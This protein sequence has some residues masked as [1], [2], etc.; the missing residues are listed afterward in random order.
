MIPPTEEHR[1]LRNIDRISE[2]AQYTI[3]E[4]YIIRNLKGQD[5]LEEI[6]SSDQEGILQSLTG[7]F[8]VPGLVYTFLYKGD[9]LVIEI[10]EKKTEFT[11][12]VPLVFCMNTGQGYFTGLNLN[13]LPGGVRLKFLQAFYETFK[14]FFNKI[15][16]LTDNN[17]LAWNKRFVEFVKSGGTQKMLKVFNSKTAS[18]F[19]FAYRKY[20]ITN[21]KQLRMIEYGEWPYIPFY[22]PKNAFRGINQ[23]QMYKL[24]YES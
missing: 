16:A 7:G 8:P 11:D 10:A 20:L 15:D 17:K 22:E 4:K 6:E 21:V 3:F 18:N 14:G 12:H 5:K 13:M 24:Y 1:H 23:L 9:Q 2:I 19:G